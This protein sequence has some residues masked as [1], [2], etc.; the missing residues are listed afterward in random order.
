MNGSDVEEVFRNVND[1]FEIHGPAQDHF[2]RQRSHELNQVNEQEKANE[3][4]LDEEGPHHGLGQERR[5]QKQV[6]QNEHDAGQLA[7]EPSLAFLEH[8]AH[9]Q[10]EIIRKVYVVE[11]Q[12]LVRVPGFKWTEEVPVRSA[13]E[14][15]QHDQRDPQ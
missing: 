9:G 15:A 1:V 14:S 11:R 4:E 2:D 7:Q 12:D 13:Q 10:P 3:T 8:L 5:Q 6:G